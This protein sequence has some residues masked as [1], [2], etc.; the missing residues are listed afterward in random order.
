MLV[1][2]NTYI[3]FKIKQI[4]Y[5][6]YRPWDVCAGIVIAQEA[7]AIIT[8]SSPSF[9]SA[10]GSFYST[11]DQTSSSSN[12]TTPFEVTPEILTG[13]KYLV[14]RGIQGEDG[15]TGLVAQRRIVQEFYGCVDDVAVE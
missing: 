6:Q 5:I 8:G 14:V 13:R 3:T 12:D 1:R 7:G 11:Q 4:P 10:L 9:A 2:I 15:E